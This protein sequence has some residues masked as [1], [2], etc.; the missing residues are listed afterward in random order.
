V[1]YLITEFDTSFRGRI[2]TVHKV[3]D[4][5]VIETVDDNKDTRFYTVDKLPEDRCRIKGS[6]A[7]STVE[8]AILYHV[9][10]NDFMAAAQVLAEAARAKK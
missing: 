6:A 5:V 9:F 2:R 10:G 4:I 3:H 1:H 7:W 8:D